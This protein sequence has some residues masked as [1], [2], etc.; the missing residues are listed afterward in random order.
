MTA[1]L[2]SLTAGPSAPDS[3]SEELKAEYPQHPK[4]IKLSDR[5][6]ALTAKLRLRGYTPIS[7][8]EGTPLYHKKLKAQARLDR[9]RVKLYKQLIE[10]SFPQS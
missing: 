9:F 6:K 3:I 10:T 1:R 4:L 2:A 5:N 8:A 7:T